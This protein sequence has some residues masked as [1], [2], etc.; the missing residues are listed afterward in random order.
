MKKFI[1][2]QIS[3]T[4]N[5]MNLLL[6][7]SVI[8]NQILNISKLAVKTIKK[9]KKILLA[10]NG[11]SAADAQHIAA[12][13]VSRFYFNRPGIAAIALT[14]DTSIITSIG[15][16]YSF[17]RIFSR[18]I[19]AIGSKGDLFI[20]ISTSGNSKNIL[21][22]LDHANLNGL[23]TVGFTGAKGGLMKEKCKI[24]LHIPSDVV[25]RIQESH[26]LVGHLICSLIEEML[27]GDSRK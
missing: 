26:I 20:G 17:D 4:I 10:G 9:N 11:G 23:I 16:D 2:E 1:S 21:N 6:A 12:E 27:F 5:T 18:Q 25:P 8:Q 24:C 19:E 3:S 15:N 13:L 22:A 7:D 14:T